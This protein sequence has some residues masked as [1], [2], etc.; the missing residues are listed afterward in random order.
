MTS[1]LAPSRSR[2]LAGLLVAAVVGA[3]AVVAAIGLLAAVV[4]VP[5]EDLTREPQVV[6]EGSAYVGALSNLG[7]LVF[8]VAA[9][10][11]GLAA[12]V[13]RGRERGM[14]GAAA[15]VSALMLL[16]D[17]FL[18][19]DVV[20]PRLGVPEAVVQAAY[21]LAI[22]AI[23]F[24]YRSEMGMVAVAGVVVTLGAWAASVGMD[25]FLN[26]HPLNLDQLVE[27]GAKFVGIAVWAAVWAGLAHVTLRGRPTTG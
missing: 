18:L 23:V 22:A 12:T 14:F 6:L 7:V 9:V 27:D 19:H 5:N 3:V 20:Y 1:P 24:L 21:L 16:D 2:L 11:A 17:L 8:A 13:V 15:A 25:T 26:N 10:A 4:D